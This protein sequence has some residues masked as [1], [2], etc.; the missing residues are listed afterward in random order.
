MLVLER[1]TA[2]DYNLYSQMVFNEQIMNMNMGRVFTDEE[3]SMFFQVI[4]SCNAQNN[5]YGFYKVYS[6]HNND[7]EYIGMGALTWNDDC[8]AVE[9]EYMLLPQQWNKGYG[10]ALVKLLVQKAKESKK[11][12]DIVAITDPTNIYSKRI[13]R[14]ASF[15]LVKQYVNDDGELAEL[16]KLTKQ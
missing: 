7:R 6:V 4:L 3:A 15:E 11:G 16:Y 10:T 2:E 13:L 12:V 9:I 14:H 1:Y 5:E 8:N